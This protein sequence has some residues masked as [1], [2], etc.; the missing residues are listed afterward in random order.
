MTRLI[1]APMAGVSD[2]AFRT[3]CARMGADIT[4]TEMVSSRAL[5]YGDKKTLAL[6]KPAESGRCG[7]Q[8]FGNDPAVMARAAAIVEGSA[9]PDFIDVNMGCPTPKIAGNGD[10]CAL[11]RDIPLASRIVRAMSDAVSVPIT[12]KMRLGWDKSCINAV[13]LA[14]AVEDAGASALTVHGRTKAMGYSGRADR[15]AI[16]HVR[17]AVSIPVMANGDIVSAEDALWCLKV[18][19]CDGLMVGRGAF[20]DPWIFREIAAALRGLSIPE[21]PALPERMEMAIEQFLISRSDKGE[22]I[23]CLEARKYFGWYLRGIPFSARYRDQLNRLET[24]ADVFRIR[25]RILQ[26]LG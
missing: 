25:D 2:Y 7:V 15:D 5:V 23:A 9:H 12:V 24:E 16:R 14:Q 8:L 6:M 10:G 13:E 20:G 17:D 3:L 11:M 1:L 21:H 22:H 18:T 4:V 19:R 26:E